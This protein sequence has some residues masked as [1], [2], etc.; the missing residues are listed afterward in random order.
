MRFQSVKLNYE[1]VIIPKEIRVT[2]VVCFSL[3][4]LFI[5]REK[6]ILHH[7]NKPFCWRNQLRLKRRLFSFFFLDGT[8][9]Q[10]GTSPPK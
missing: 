9:V 3:K 6:T 7:S 1:N 5:L 10:R 8:T 2:A 4:P